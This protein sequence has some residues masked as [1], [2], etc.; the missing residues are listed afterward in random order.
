[1]RLVILSAIAVIAAQPALASSIEPITG[2]RLANDS[3]INVTCDGCPPPKPPEERGAYQVPV[4]AD[5]VQQENVETMGDQ[6]RVVRVDRW[7]GGSPSRFVTKVP[8]PSLSAVDAEQTIAEAKARKE[9]E[10]RLAAEAAKREQ[11]AEQQ[12]QQQAAPDDGIDEAAT[13]SAVDNAEA[14][15]EAALPG[16]DLRLK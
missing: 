2:T 14:P 6:E 12:A 10:L 15:A 7:M 13:T 9:E 11:E 4:I 8:P 3:I 16:M 1:M 5:G